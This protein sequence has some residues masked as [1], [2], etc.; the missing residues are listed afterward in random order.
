MTR[1]APLHIGLLGIA[2]ALSSTGCFMLFDPIDTYEDPETFDPPSQPQQPMEQAPVISMSGIGWPPLG[3][4]KGLKLFV[5]DANANLSTLRF[6]FANE[7]ERKIGGGSAEVFLTG[8]ELGEGFGTLSLTATDTRSAFVVREVHDLLVDLSP[9]KITLGQTVVRADGFLELWVGDAWI[10]GKVDLVWKGNTLTHELSPVYPETLGKTWDYS[11]V[12]F[13][14]SGLAQGKGQA[15]IIAT[16]AA[17]NTASE[18]FTL[19]IDGDP[20][21]VSIASPIAGAKL[22]G[23]VAVAIN[24]SDPGGGPVFIELSLGGA[25]AG[26]AAGPTASLSLSTSDFA[27]G[28]AKLVAVARDQAGNESTASVD[29]V[30]E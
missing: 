19:N 12:K 30:I 6:S 28:P 11:L 29:V 2:V 25:P 23:K 13:P 3:P 8:A 15:A 10:L 4:K 14:M 1:A 21:A 7:G 20:P 27:A 26:N 24:A 5:T 17:G 9:P 22:S 16:D 18:P